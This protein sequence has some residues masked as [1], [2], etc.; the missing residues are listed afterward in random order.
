M[1]SN[2]QD[3]TGLSGSIT[4]IGTAT[5]LIRF[6]GFT[7]LTDPN[8]LHGGERIHLG[9]GMHARRLTEPALDI[10]Q[11]PPLDLVVLSHMHE[12]HFDRV[13]AERLKKDLPIVTTGEAARELGRL[14]FRNPMSLA[15]WSTRLFARNGGG[16]RVTAMPGRHAPLALNP[17]FPSVMGSM[18]EFTGATGAVDLRIYV[19]GDTLF[20]DRLKQIPLRYPDIDIALVHL[21]GTRLLGLLLTMDAAQGVETVKVMRAGVNIP[22]HY[23]D[24]DVFRSPLDDF[25]RAA[26]RAGLEEKIAYLA[27]G[28]IYQFRTRGRSQKPLGVIA[29]RDI[30]PS[31]GEPSRGMTIDLGAHRG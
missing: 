2:K 1:A 7:V 16:L 15:T 12:D 27:H 20:H 22:I 21:G 9:Y 29:K 10:D 28:D 6:G 23:N 18:L 30:V 11:L 3:P 31:I 4:F 5:V 26:E 19:T 24:Y 13:A 25:R 14:G 8:F 17:L